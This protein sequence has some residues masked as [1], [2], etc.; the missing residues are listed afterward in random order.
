MGQFIFT[1]NSGGGGGGNVYPFQLPIT[2]FAPAPIALNG[3][4][5]TREFTPPGAGEACLCFLSNAG[6]EYVLTPGYNQDFAPMVMSELAIIPA[7]QAN[8][9]LLYTK[10]VSGQPQL[11]YLTDAAVEYQITPPSGG[12]GNTLIPTGIVDPA[13]APYVVQPGTLAILQY[14][15]VDSTITFANGV[16]DGDRI[17]VVGYYG[18]GATPG[19]INIDRGTNISSSTWNPTNKWLE[20]ADGEFKALTFVWSGPLLFWILES[21]SIYNTV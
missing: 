3:L 1:T 2:P 8:K 20:Y 5:Y 10:D 16:D 13:A 6:V 9:G 15:A 7:V 14:T 12:G 19:K 18:G 11:F 4:L 17:G 21:A